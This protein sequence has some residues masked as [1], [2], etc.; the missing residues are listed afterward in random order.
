MNRLLIVLVSFLC[1]NGLQ[2]QSIIECH[3][4]MNRYDSLMFQKDTVGAL[5][6]LSDL[7]DACKKRISAGAHLRIANVFQNIDEAKEKEHLIAAC[8]KGLLTTHYNTEE[9]LNLYSKLKERIPNID[10]IDLT[11]Q[12]LANLTEPNKK[13]RREIIDIIIQDQVLRNNK[14]YKNCKSHEFQV[15]LDYIDPDTVANHLELIECYKEY[16]TLDST[17]LQRFVDIVSNKGYVPFSDSL[18][19]LEMNV[20]INHTS[21]ISFRENLD[22]LYKHSVMIGSISPKVYAWYKGYN[23]EYFKA[24]HVYYYTHGESWI[25]ELD[26]T[27]EEKAKINRRRKEI[28][29]PSLP[30]SVWDYGVW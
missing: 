3:N 7:P 15:R 8:N 11:T 23:E 29:L 20:L 9:F 6:N 16:R 26:L 17:N 12:S 2:S 14:K 24:P 28:G 21:H 30:A 22:S 18:Q 19:F 5:H 10:L 25:E 4:L 27:E 13:L 1:S